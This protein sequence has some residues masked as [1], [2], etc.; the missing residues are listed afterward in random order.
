[1]TTDPLAYRVNQ[2]ARTAWMRRLD[3]PDPPVPLSAPEVGA[4]LALPGD[5]VPPAVV[6]LE[7]GAKALGWHVLVVYSR[8]T[9][10]GAKGQ[11]LRVADAVSVRMWRFPGE[12][13][14]AL[15]VGG[16]AD[17]GWFWNGPLTVAIMAGNPGVA[18][19]KAHVL[20]K[21]EGGE[22]RET[23]LATYARGKSESDKALCKCGKLVTI[24]KDG[25]LRQHGPK[26][27]R[28]EGR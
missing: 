7:H 11:A 13:A 18:A 3:A 25:S 20:G 2:D 27:A 15:W 19:V 9:V 12:R 1:M 28:C 4:R 21:D 16:K 8:G 14:V 24:N 6:E 5:P 26:G 10:M 17:G 23:M 22:V